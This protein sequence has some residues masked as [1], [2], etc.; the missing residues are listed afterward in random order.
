MRPRTL[1][2]I[3]GEDAISGDE[4][5]SGEAF[6]QGRGHFSRAQK[7]DLQLRTH[8]RVVAGRRAAQK[9]K[10]QFTLPLHTNHLKS[11]KD[12]VMR[13]RL[14]ANKERKHMK[15]VWLSGVALA[16]SIEAGNCG[17]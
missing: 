13:A 16:L 1:K 5:G 12:W 6:G 14:L 3:T 17:G 9:V 8:G 11:G 2:R 10:V 4:A 15:K 7:T